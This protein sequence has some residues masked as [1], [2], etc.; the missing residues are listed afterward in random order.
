VEVALEDPA[1]RERLAT[2]LRE[3][4]A[5]R[6]AREEQERS[7]MFLDSMTEEVRAFAD[8]HGLDAPTAERLLAELTRQHE[9]FT[10]VRQDVRDGNLS[11]FD[12]RKEFDALREERDA[13]VAG[14]LGEEDA[15]ALTERL[16]G[17][18]GRRGPPF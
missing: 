17:E 15:A 2:L 13:A 11:W 12:A 10:A 5:A 8:E 9:A 6:E 18:R 1:V 4:E 16:W 7:A 14:I 3:E